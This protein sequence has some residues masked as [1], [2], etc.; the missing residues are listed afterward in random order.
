LQEDS[1][2]QQLK[3]AKQSFGGGLKPKSGKEE[4]K[5]NLLRCHALQLLPSRA[6]PD[7]QLTI[8]NQQIYQADF[9]SNR[10]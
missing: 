4:E 6:K 8:N 1:D 2:P 5:L 9:I 7:Q 3:T 10:A